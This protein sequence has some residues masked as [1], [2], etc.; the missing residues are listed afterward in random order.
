[1]SIS[2]K[3]LILHSLELAADGQIALQARSEEMLHS[4]QALSLIESLHL[5]FSG[6]AAKG[7]GYYPPENT[8]TF[9]EKLDLLL[10]R[11]LDFHRFSVDSGSVLVEE[12]K[13]YEFI[14]QGV[15][16][17]AHYEHVA[18]EYLLIML[19]E[20]KTSPAVD[21]SLELTAS[22][23]L[24]TSSIQLAARIDITDMQ[25]NAE[26]RRYVSY[27]KG[28]AGR[29]IADFFVEFLGCDDGLDVKLQNTVLMQAVDDYCQATQLDKEEKQAY[30]AEVKSYCEQQL[31]DGEEIVVGELA[32]AL[33]T[34]DENVDFYQ[35]A[36]ENYPLEE[37]FPAD[38]ST[39]KKL[40]KCFGQ[41]KGVSISFEQK[42][43]G[44]RVFYDEASDTLTIVGIPP[45]LREQ[46]KNNN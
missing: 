1:M 2:L 5:N 33:P 23:Y 34:D 11:E 27:V 37:Q 19:L 28:R 13:K 20:N 9:K 21:E 14:E 41:G 36:A 38:R 40:A 43:L 42:L 6:R 25:R 46:L 15:L 30:K 35:F 3:H 26:S 44:E 31:K 18:G 24:E 4:E 7:F 17:L 8:S 39:L 12:L 32:K 45:N 29:K 22:R 16:L 10:S